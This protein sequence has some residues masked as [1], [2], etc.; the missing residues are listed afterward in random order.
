MDKA[1]ELLK[2]C[3]GLYEEYNERWKK[4]DISKDKLEAVKALCVRY[5]YH[6]LAVKTDVSKDLL[7]IDDVR[8]V[9]MYRTL[10]K[11]HS[12]EQDDLLETSCVTLDWNLEYTKDGIWAIPPNPITDATIDYMISSCRQHA[13]TCEPSILNWCKKNAPDALSDLAPV[14]LWDI[15]NDSYFKYH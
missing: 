4:A 1:T 15:M 8:S 12:L 6:T 14:P 2:D 7:N 11:A 5:M 3:E 9:V 10:R 13:V